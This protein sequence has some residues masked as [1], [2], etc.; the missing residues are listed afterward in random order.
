MIANAP[1]ATNPA[2]LAVLVFAH[3][4]TGGGLKRYHYDP[5]KLKDAHG[6][7]ADACRAA[8][9]QGVDVVLVDNTHIQRWEYAV[10]ERIA[11]EASYR[12]AVAEI[13]FT[14]L[15]TRKVATAAT[16]ATQIGDEPL[17]DRATRAALAE[18]ARRNVHGVELDTIYS[19]VRIGSQ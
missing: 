9:S 19:K 2:T 15:P 4:P 5:S 18:L 16:A 11:Q 8:C 3:H 10:Y 13:A 12:L 1:T 17:P 7:C 6:A 14:I